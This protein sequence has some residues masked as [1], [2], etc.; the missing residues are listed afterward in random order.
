MEIS[1]DTSR[2]APVIKTMEEYAGVCANLKNVT[3]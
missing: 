3:D 1:R 2:E